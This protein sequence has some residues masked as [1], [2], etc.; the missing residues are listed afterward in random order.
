MRI[1]RR[2]GFGTLI[3]AGLLLLEIVFVKSYFLA[4][5]LFILLIGHCAFFRDPS[6]KLP[7]PSGPVSPAMGKVVEISEVNESRYLNEDAIK[8]GI[9]LS[10]FDVH[11]TRAPY[12]AKVSYLEYV[13]GKFLNA[14][15]AESVNKNECNWIGMEKDGRRVMVRQIS[16]AIARR[17]CCDVKI[18]DSV[19][20]G[21][22]MGIIC[23][24]SR[25]ECFLPKRFF[26]PTISV[27]AR[28]KAGETLLGEWI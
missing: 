21:G 17:I 14:L 27:G 19:E 3:L 8:I 12:E 13:P 15:R 4:Y 20:R 5:L 28:V 7:K 10:V 24:G 1:D 9:F 16:G 2:V 11:V 25:V 18:G 22:K 6:P 26:R 23:Y